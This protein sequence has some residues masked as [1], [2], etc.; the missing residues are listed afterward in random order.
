MFGV[1]CSEFWDNRHLRYIYALPTVSSS[2]YIFAFIL[3]QQNGFRTANRSNK[4]QTFW[5]FLTNLETLK[6]QFSEI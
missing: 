2:V 1:G 4:I 3:V 6:R 5:E